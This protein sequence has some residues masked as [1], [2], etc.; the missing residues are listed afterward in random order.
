MEV[1]IKAPSILDVQTMD[2]ITEIFGRTAVGR[3]SLHL[4]VFDMVNNGINEVDTRLFR[5]R[6]S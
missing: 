3:L 5:A 4:L 2:L 6:V 1:N